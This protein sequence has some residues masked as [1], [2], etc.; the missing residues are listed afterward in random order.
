MNLKNIILTAFSVFALASC[1]TNEKLPVQTLPQALF[2]AKGGGDAK[3][4]IARGGE[5]R[6]VGLNAT[7]DWTVSCESDWVKISPMSGTSATKDVTITVETENTADDDRIAEVIIYDAYSAPSDTLFV[8]QKGS[9]GE[10]NGTIKSVEAFFQ[11][12]DQASSLVESDVVQLME[13]IDL[14]GEA[15]RPIEKFYAVFEGNGHSVSNFTVASDKEFAGIFLQNFGTIQN[16]TVGSADGKKWDGTSKICFAGE[17]LA[18][19]AGL[20]AE[21]H[22]TVKNVKNFAAVDFNAVNTADA[23]V[24]GVVGQIGSAAAVISGCENHGTVTFTGELGYRGCMGGVLGLNGQTGAAIENCLNTAAVVKSTVNQKEF[25]MGGIVGRAN[26]QLFVR[27]CIN[28]APVSY[29]SSDTPGSYLHIAGVIGAAY[30]DSQ[31]VEC[32]NKGEVSSCIKQVNRIGGIAGTMNT[33]GLIESCVNDGN[34]IVDQPSNANWQGVGGI[35]GFEEKSTAA[36]PFIIKNCTNSAAVTMNLNNTTTHANEASA[37][38]IIG[39]SCSVV[40]FV[41]N[42]NNGKITSRNTGGTS[43]HT[44][45]IIGSYIK[46]SGL[47]T[48]GNSNK[49]AVSFEASKGTAGGFV[50]FIAPISA[51]A[52]IK[53][54]SSRAD[55]SGSVASN[56]GAIAGV[57][58]ASLNACAAAGTVGGVEVTNANLAALIQGSASTGTPVACYV[59][60]GAPVEFI[61]VNPASLT[62]NAAGEGKTVSVSS[63]CE[64]TVASSASWVTLSVSAGNG[65]ATVTL[66]AAENPDKQERSAVITFTSKKD[67][68]LTATVNADQKGKPSAI[69]GNQIKTAE[70]LKTFLSIAPDA[71]AGETYTIENDIDFSAETLAPA[72]SYAGVLDG[73]GHKITVKD[74]LDAVAVALFN[75]LTGTVKNLTVAGSLKSVYSGSAEHYLSA[76]AATVNGGLVENC[77]NEAALT[78]A[79]TTAT[80]VYC[81]LGGLVGKLQ[82]DGA[83]VKNCRNTGKLVLNGGFPAMVGGVLAYG[84]TSSSKPTLSIIGCSNSAEVVI[85]HTGGAWDYIGGVVGKMGASS[86][87]TPFTMYYIKDC[88]FSGKLSIVK[89]PKIR[90]G[91]VFAHSGTSVNYDISGN[92]FS[93][94]IDITST[95]AVDRIFAGAGPGF[96]EAGAVGTV[97]NCV[98][99]GSITAVNGGNLYLAGIYGNNGSASV[100]IDGCKTTSTFS[101][102]GFTSAKSTGAIAARPNLAGFTIKNCK[103]AGKLASTSG[104][105]T[106]ISADNIADWM[107]KGF[108]TSV[109]VILENNGFNAE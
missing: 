88:T 79:P 45:G 27:N 24:G 91:G 63:N 60:G 82:L 105:Q 59:E 22:G 1:V 68:A 73:K 15:I 72:A 109:N 54:E 36:Q 23:A 69:P 62:F 103:I 98:A 37:G 44:G 92:V 93:G 80:N 97:S 35:C 100:V 86:A 99:S 83:A 81:H 38:G 25:A 32:T 30:N 61:S 94:S 31:I 46:G 19:A 43:A 95:E 33:G 34:V 28:Q 106:T 18:T 58:S 75:V 87:S 90:G 7:C 96:S 9:S 66:T 74:E 16:L 41:G 85:D 102:G 47:K 6:L 70:H 64:W 10:F 65:D 42:V 21:N 29:E 77:V 51:S 108:A 3:V 4:E 67:A 52:V 89:A 39:L 56:I 71:E 57:T 107:F 20:V 2:E 53:E 11:F 49:G 13:D 14:G 17:I 76:I 48:S 78:L 104:E 8:I 26:S 50:G 84:V 5:T 12:I 101:I 40:E 55:I